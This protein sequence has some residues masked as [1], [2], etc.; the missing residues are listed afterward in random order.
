MVSVNAVP[1]PFREPPRL[2]PEFRPK[3]ISPRHALLI[4]PFYRKDPHA[5]F[6]KHVL[7]PSLALPS[8]RFLGSGKI[9]TATTTW[10]RRGPRTGMQSAIASLATP[11]SA[12]ADDPLGACR[13]HRNRIRDRHAESTLHSRL[14]CTIRWAGLYWRP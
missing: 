1:R 5:S 13:V 2:A 4:N 3:V 12:L 8:I 11:G 7:T 10:A 14:S 6:G 9:C